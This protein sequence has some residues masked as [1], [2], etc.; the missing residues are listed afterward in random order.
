MV[1]MRM[2]L[3]IGLMFAALLPG[4]EK[5]LTFEVASIKPTKPGGR[6]GGMRV[7]PGGQEFVTE[8]VSLRFM[9][10]FMYWVPLRQVT[11]GPA[12]LDTDQWDIAAKADRPHDL[13]DLREMFRNMLADEFKLKLRKD[14]KEGPVYALMVDKSGL[15]MKLNDAPWDFEVSV[16]PG[17]GGV[18]IGKRV[19][20]QRLCYQLEQILQRDERP[21]IDRTGLPGY[22]DFTLAFLP[23]KLPP[24]FNLDNLPEAMRDRPSIFDALK[25]QLGLKLEA[26]KGPVDYYSVDHVEKPAGN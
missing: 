1:S 12:W 4:Q 25:Q 7:M 3:A 14:V 9:I 23:E 26:Q 18:T 20:I 2:M 6:G 21:V 15:K 24:G 17:P 11:G 5:R 19:S 13:D 22:Y 10:G 8:G 16:K